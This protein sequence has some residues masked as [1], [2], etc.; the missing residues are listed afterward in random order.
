MP[1]IAQA[2]QAAARA[3]KVGGRLVYVGAGSSGRLGVLDAAEC[4]PTFGASAREVRALLAGGARAIF[5]A[6]A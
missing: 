6:A 1:A 3:L 4:A 2:S 5:R